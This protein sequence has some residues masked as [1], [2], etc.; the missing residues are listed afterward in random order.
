MPIKGPDVNISRHMTGKFIVLEGITSTGKTTLGKMLVERLKAKGTDAFFNHEPT[1]HTPFGRISRCI[2]EKNQCL[3]KDIE[4]AGKL[5]IIKKSGVLSRILTK[6]RNGKKLSELER[7]LLYIADR[8]EDLRGTILP[9]IARSRTCMQDRYELSTYAYASTKN[10]SYSRLK[11]LHDEILREVYIVPDIIL[12]FDLDPSLAIKRLSNA[13][14]KPVDIY[15]TLPKIKKTR[16][17][18]IKL[19]K[20]K[21]L[22]KK[23]FIID[24]RPPIIEVFEDICLKL[25][26]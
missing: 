5:N 18:Y 2:V 12:Y 25:Q 17:A 16:E 11:K 10:I 3:P 7:Q 9:Q 19:L 26:M 6:I 8:Y 24:V 4:E 20:K 15:E 14:G 23:L 1:T 21:E 13:S 22:Y